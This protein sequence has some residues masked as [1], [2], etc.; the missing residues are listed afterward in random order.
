MDRWAANPFDATLMNS[1]SKVLQSAF[2]TA[3]VKMVDKYT[4]TTAVDWSDQADAICRAHRKKPSLVLE[5]PYFEDVEYCLKLISLD[6]YPDQFEAF[7]EKR[8]LPRLFRIQSE[9]VVAVTKNPGSP[10]RQPTSD[11]VI[12]YGEVLVR[13]ADSTKEMIATELKAGGWTLEHDFRSS[14]I[15]VTGRAAAK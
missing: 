13:L 7:K 2:L 1:A 14:T 5:R 11:E 4:D 12:P 10:Y 15:L 9:I 3:A 6:G 8:S